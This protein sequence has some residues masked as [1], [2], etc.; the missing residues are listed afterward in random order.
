MQNA[1]CRMENVMDIQDRTFAFACRIVRLYR[2]MWNDRSA[3]PLAYQLVD[4]GTSVGSNL[5]EAE[6]GQSKADFISKCRISLK[7][8]RETLYWL[9]LIVASDFLPE[10]RVAT[11][12]DEANEIVAILTTIVKNASKSPRR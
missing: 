10:E 3:R 8:A 4:A 1:E 6:A 9:R 5:E 7:E 2:S 11:L 12:R